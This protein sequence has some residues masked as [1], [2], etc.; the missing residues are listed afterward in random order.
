[1]PQQPH[2]NDYGHQAQAHGENPGKPAVISSP[3]IYMQHC[4]QQQR[5][6]QQQQMQQQL[7]QQRQLKERS[8]GL[9][10]LQGNA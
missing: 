10:R 2:H 8:A 5:Q 4:R 7:A 6:Q 3:L 9:K 1:M